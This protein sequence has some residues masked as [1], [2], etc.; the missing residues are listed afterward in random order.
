M[1]RAIQIEVVDLSLQSRR[2][3]RNG[4]SSTT[5]DYTVVW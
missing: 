3:L 2:K 5:S 1:E 4:W